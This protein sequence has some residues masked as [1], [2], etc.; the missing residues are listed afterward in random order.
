[1]ISDPPLCHVLGLLGP[2]NSAIVLNGPS[3]CIRYN[4]A[5][6]SQAVSLEYVLPDVF[7]TKNHM[8]SEIP[9]PT[10]FN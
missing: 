4:I 3:R 2:L 5:I 7:N 10:L 6:C 1:M 8:W 9:A